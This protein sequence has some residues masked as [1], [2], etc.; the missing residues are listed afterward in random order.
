MVIRTKVNP[1]L[2]VSSW[3]LRAALLLKP[4]NMGATTLPAPHYQT[5]YMAQTLF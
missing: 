5:D 2:Q 1:A 3:S 4:I